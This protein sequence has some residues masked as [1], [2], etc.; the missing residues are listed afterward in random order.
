L[1]D[2]RKRR[3]IE[4]EHGTIS[5]TEWKGLREL[6]LVLGDQR[7]G[8]VEEP[9]ENRGLFPVGRDENNT[10]NHISV[11]VEDSD[12]TIILAGDTSYNEGLMLA[13]K[14]DGVGSNTQVSAATLAAIKRFAATQPTI[15]LPTHDPESAARLAARR[16]VPAAA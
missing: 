1:S 15:Y 5:A 8:T 11:L 9:S 4:K 3:E 7:W 12:A 16:S 14:V 10:P 2:P 6:L 13:G